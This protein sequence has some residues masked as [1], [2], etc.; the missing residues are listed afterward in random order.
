MLS[1]DKAHAPIAG[2]LVV[3]NLD[4][5]VAFYSAVFGAVEAE[6]YADKSGEVWYSVLQV[7]GVPLQ[8]MEPFEEMAWWPGPRALARPPA[9][10][11]TCSP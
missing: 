11:A 5:A 8:L 7:L 6:R 2:F 9:A 1:T 3:P 4:R 10:T